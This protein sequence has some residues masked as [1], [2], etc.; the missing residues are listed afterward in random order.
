MLAYKRLFQTTA[1]YADVMSHAVHGLVIRPVRNGQPGEYAVEAP[2][3]ERRLADKVVALFDE[4][5]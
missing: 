3:H 5:R 1:P 2:N 4:G